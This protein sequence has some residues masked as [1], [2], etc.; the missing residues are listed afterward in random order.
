M[1]TSSELVRELFERDGIPKTPYY[2]RI[3]R[4]EEMHGLDADFV[5]VE[6]VSRRMI[7]SEPYLPRASE[8]IEEDKEAFWDGLKGMS[9]GFL[10]IVGIAYLRR[11]TS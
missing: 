8:G 3:Q 11:R 5:I 2:Q 9:I 10:M 1:E 6:T 4:V 7:S